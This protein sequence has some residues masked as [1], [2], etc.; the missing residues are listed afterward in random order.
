MDF[1]MEGIEA[2]FRLPN[3]GL[4]YTEE[5]SLA[6]YHSLGKPI[7]LIKGWLLDHCKHFTGMKLITLPGQVLIQLFHK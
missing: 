6:Y 5:D 2:V 7:E 3:E 4:P 1:S